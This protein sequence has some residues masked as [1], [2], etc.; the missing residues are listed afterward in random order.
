MT[1]AESWSAAGQRCRERACAKTDHGFVAGTFARVVIML[2]I[3]IA[4]IL[5]LALVALLVVGAMSAPSP[6]LLPQSLSLSLSVP[7]AG[8]V[9]RLSRLSVQFACRDKVG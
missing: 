9:W 3:F 8:F 4:L 5:L 7:S 6:L 1:R 2:L